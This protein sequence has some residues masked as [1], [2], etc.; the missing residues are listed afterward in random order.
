MLSIHSK[1]T[2]CFTQFLFKTTNPKEKKLLTLYCSRLTVLVANVVNGPDSV[3]DPNWL[4]VIQQ[5]TAT[6]KTVLGYVRTGYCRCSR[7][8]NFLF[9]MSSEM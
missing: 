3:T 4:N 8:I 7:S 9:Q 6:G 2:R 5:A 1:I